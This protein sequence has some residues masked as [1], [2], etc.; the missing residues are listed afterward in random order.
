MVELGIRPYDKA[1]IPFIMNSWLKSY[2]HNSGFGKLLTYDTYF[3]HHERLIK[4][5]LITSS[6]TI[7]HEKDDPTLILGY[8]A[9]ERRPTY[10]QV[11]HFAFVKKEFRLFGIFKQLLAHEKLELERCTATH[12]TYPGE[13]LREKHVGMSY[14]PYLAF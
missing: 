11:I 1:D 9:F 10:G 13:A 12:L 8:V 5:L 3:Q 2:K 14:N 6:V 4:T 7:A